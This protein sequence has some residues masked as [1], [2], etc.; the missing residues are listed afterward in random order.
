MAGLA[1]LFPGQGSQQ[2]GMGKALA[3][4]SPRAAEVFAEAD[5]TL[6]FALSKLCFEGPEDELTLT[7]N[8]QPAVL[9]TSIA[10]LRLV[11]ERGL[12]PEIV[13][14]HSLGEY[15]ALVAAGALGLTDA[16]RLVAS[17]GRF[18]Q[19]AVPVGEGAMAAV[20]GLDAATVEKLCREAAQG[21]TLAAANYNAPDQIVIAG[22]RS[23]V[24]R[25]IELA[26]AAG[27]KRA[28]LL[29]VSAPFHSPL[30][31]PARVQLEPLL[32]KTP[33][34]D[35][36]LPLV[37][38]VDAALVLSGAA[39]RRGLARQVDAPVRW[40]ASVER[41]LAEGVRRFVEVGPGRVLSGLVRRIDR[42][43]VILNVEDPDS[44]ELSVAELG[45]D[46]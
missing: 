1:F 14:G 26:R 29:P 28:L 41:L 23:A 37:N 45:G 13:A 20:I 16:L 9:A 42:S 11:E 10:A 8:T 18:M 43:A 33:F 44:L 27:A 40:V 15:T 7:R 12:K 19:E 38:N 24:E 5:A 2:V 25:G 36:E 35:L 17:R 30:M 22:H 4:S 32:E 21:Q 34:R 46:A 39:A 31:A 3:A 6:G